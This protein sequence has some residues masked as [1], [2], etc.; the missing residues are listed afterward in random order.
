[1]AHLDEADAVPPRAQRFHQAVDAVAGEAEDDLDS[2]VEE[3]V[4]Y[5]V[6]FPWSERAIEDLRMFAR[7][8][9]QR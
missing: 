1:M 2:P 5:P 9:Q 4:D 6:W 3:A 7:L 8:R